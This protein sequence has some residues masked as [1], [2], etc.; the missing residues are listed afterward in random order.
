MFLAQKTRQNT[1]IFRNRY[2]IL[3]TQSVI[4][5]NNCII[6]YGED[7]FDSIEIK[8]E[9]ISGNTAPVLPD[10]FFEYC[11]YLNFRIDYIYNDQTIDKF[12]RRFQYIMNN[13]VDIDDVSAIELQSRILTHIVS[14]PR[15]N[16]NA[17][18]RIL[19]GE[20]TALH[21]LCRFNAHFNTPNNTI[22]LFKNLFFISKDIFS[23]HVIKTDSTTEPDKLPIGRHDIIPT[24]FIPSN[25]TVIQNILLF[26]NVSYDF[27][28]VT[29]KYYMSVDVIFRNKVQQFVL[30]PADELVLLGEFDA[31]IFKDDKKLNCFDYIAV[32]PIPGMI[33]FNPIS[34]RYTMKSMLIEKNIYDY[35]ISDMNGNKARFYI[36]KHLEIYV[37]FTR[38]FELKIASPTGYN[39]IVLY[40][41]NYLNNTTITIQSKTQ[42][43]MNITDLFGFDRNDILEKIKE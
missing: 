33:Q 3:A 7:F 42:R 5:E 34:H 28:K 23:I 32:S 9:D 31:S 35:I 43:M 37:Y 21:I 12:I 41:A 22:G 27:T 18:N 30:S 26:F 11:V 40:Y 10:N 15:C 29:E 2:N 17:V 38:L 14:T 8:E 1:I 4:I 24:C 39:M 6:M 20:H 36:T 19:N 13:T 16:D 25:I